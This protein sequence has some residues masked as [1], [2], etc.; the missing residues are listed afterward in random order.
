MLQTCWPEHF[1]SPEHQRTSIA[2]LAKTPSAKPE[3]SRLPPAEDVWINESRLGFSPPRG[4]RVRVCERQRSSN[5]CTLCRL[6]PFVG[7]AR[8]RSGCASCSPAGPPPTL[9]IV[10]LLV[11]V[12]VPTA[13]G[14]RQTF[15]EPHKRRPSGESVSVNCVWLQRYV[16]P[17]LS[18]P[19]MPFSSLR[20]KLCHFLYN[21]WK[22]T[23]TASCKID[24]G[25]TPVREGYLYLLMTR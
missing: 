25:A 2:G 14:P 22:I 23:S 13:T 9:H 20:I 17:L 18:D 24:A 21:M 1:H 10:F 7:R 5:C 15:K 8:T 19:L 4:T 3:K 6:R 16:F 12:S 11:R